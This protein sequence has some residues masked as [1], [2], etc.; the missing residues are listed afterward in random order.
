MFSAYGF[1][2]TPDAPLLFFTAFFLYS[3][4]NY[5]ADQNWKSVVFLSLSMAGLVYSKYQ[6][7]LVIGFVV[8]SNIKLLKSY[9]FW[10]AGLVR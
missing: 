4:K 7:V 1:F 9:K 2:T 8:I 6:A 10:I 5:L 3:Y